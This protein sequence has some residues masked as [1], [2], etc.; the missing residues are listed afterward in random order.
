MTTTTNSISI[1]RE[2]NESQEE[3]IS[4]INATTHVRGKNESWSQEENLPWNF[5]VDISD[6]GRHSSSG[7]VTRSPDPFQ[8]DAMM[9]DHDLLCEGS[10]TNGD[11]TSK[12]GRPWSSGEAT[13]TDH[14][15][16]L[17]M[18]SSTMTTKKGR[19]LVA[20]TIG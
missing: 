6:T 11:S 18:D 1:V 10:I 12:S 20:K 8:T 2:K 19:N 9:R 15:K 3:L 17:Q 5:R 14:V 16:G 13:A 4:N 7:G